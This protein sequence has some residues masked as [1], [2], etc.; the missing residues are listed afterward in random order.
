MRKMTKSY[1]LAI[2]IV[3]FFLSSVSMAVNAEE[4]TLQFSKYSKNLQR[5]PIVSDSGAIYDNW[6]WAYFAGEVSVSGVL[7]IEDDA[8]FLIPDANS[9]KILPQ[10]IGPKYGYAS[11]IEKILL[12][13]DGQNIDATLLPKND[14]E[15]KAK[16]V[17]Q[18]KLAWESQ[19]LTKLLGSD[20]AIKLLENKPEVVKINVIV[21]IKNVLTTVE[22]DTRH[23]G[24]DVIEIR[25]PQ[26]TSKRLLALSNTPKFQGC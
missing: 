18:L 6:R 19:F 11:K 22:C 16:M 7:W 3:C 13:I 15:A 2:S 4:E 25:L 24:A 23:Y 10:V 26:D 12:S 1:F 21:K 8:Y 9:S 5:K 14:F 20:E 17:R